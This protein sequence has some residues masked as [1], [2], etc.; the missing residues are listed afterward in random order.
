MRLEKESKSCEYSW[1]RL[2][3]W[4]MKYDIKDEKLAPKGKL[5]IE[6]AEADMPVLRQIRARFKNCLLYTSD[7]ADE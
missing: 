6:W 3:L 2:I 5:R 1:K 7:A 4:V